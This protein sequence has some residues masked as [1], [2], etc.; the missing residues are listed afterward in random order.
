MRVVLATA[1]PWLRSPITAESGTRASVR[2]TSLNIAW[3]VISLSGR[4]SMPGWCISMANHVMPWCFGESGAVR[5]MSMPRSA[6]WPSD[7]HT[8][9]PSTTHSSPSW[10]ARHVRPARS[11]PAPGSLN[12]WHQARWPVTMSRT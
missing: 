12:S 7:V 9:W 1:Q 5:A 11:D 6:T 3:P 8:F 10:T 2:N 4:T